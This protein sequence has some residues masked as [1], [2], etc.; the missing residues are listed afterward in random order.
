MAKLMKDQCVGV[1]LDFGCKVFSADTKDDFLA[2]LETLESRMTAQHAN[3]LS[4]AYPHRFPFHR[5]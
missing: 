3:D 1:E 2:W 4:W 5:D